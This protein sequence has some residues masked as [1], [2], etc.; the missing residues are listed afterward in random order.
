MLDTS[1]SRVSGYLRNSIFRTPKWYKCFNYKRCIL[2]LRVL[3]LDRMAFWG[4]QNVQKRPTGSQITLSRRFQE[5]WGFAISGLQMLKINVT[6]AQYLDPRLTWTFLCCQNVEQWLSW[7]KVFSTGGLY[8][9]VKIAFSGH[10]NEEKMLNESLNQE[11]HEPWRIS[12]SG[13]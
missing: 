5:T 1:S 3:Q 11:F 6:K 12:F 4:H 10:Q 13:H 8:Y 7:N 2:E 9:T